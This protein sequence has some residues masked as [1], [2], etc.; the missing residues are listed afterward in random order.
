MVWVLLSFNLRVYL[1]VYC[2]NCGFMSRGLLFFWWW[3]LWW[4]REE[5]ERGGGSEREIRRLSCTETGT[6][7]ENDNSVK[8]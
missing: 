4:W 8:F 1:W 5:R 2:W 6:G 7:T 3:R